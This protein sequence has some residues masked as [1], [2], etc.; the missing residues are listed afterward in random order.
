MRVFSRLG[1]VALAL[2]ALAR[3]GVAQETG[4]LEG[5]ITETGGSPIPDALI[6]IVGTNRGA[7]TG[8]D[9]QYRLA[10]LRAGEFTVRVT[11]LGYAAV[12]RPVTIALGQTARVDVA[13]T[14]DGGDET[15]RRC[16]AAGCD[17][18]MV[19]P[20]PISELLRQIREWREG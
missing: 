17:S 5:R 4:A 7:R 20:V 18:V 12:S 2:L 8:E 15:L 9:G 11:R 19:K 13:L 16:R 14:G 3:T 6:T 10:N 1:M